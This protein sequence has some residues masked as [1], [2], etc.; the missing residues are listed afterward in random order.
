[1][2]VQ[3]YLSVFNSNDKFDIELYAI[4]ENAEMN[5]ILRIGESYQKNG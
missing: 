1:M 4:N 5:A 3:E 2:T